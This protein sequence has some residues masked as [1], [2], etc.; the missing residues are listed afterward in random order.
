MADLP[1]QELQLQWKL[2]RIEAEVL[3]IVSVSTGG[4][5][6]QP[7][8]IS[9]STEL[10]GWG[11]LGVYCEDRVCFIKWICHVILRRYWLERLNNREVNAI[12]AVVG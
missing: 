11:S 7:Y 12:G 1:L 4:F 8:R 5:K 9:K 3:H 6:T 2:I 10:A